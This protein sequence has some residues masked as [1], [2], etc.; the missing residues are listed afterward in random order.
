MRIYRCIKSIAYQLDKIQ[1]LNKDVL[2]EG[3]ENGLIWEFYQQ[4]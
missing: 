3:F 4:H 1:E 2:E